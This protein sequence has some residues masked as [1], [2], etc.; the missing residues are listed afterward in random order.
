MIMTTMI[1]PAAFRNVPTLLGVGL[2]SPSHAQ[3]ALIQIGSLSAEQQHCEST[4][5]MLPPIPTPTASMPPIRSIP[6]L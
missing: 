5:V 2:R 6:M 3:V 1:P 4:R